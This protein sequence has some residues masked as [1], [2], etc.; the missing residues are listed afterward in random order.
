M[1]FANREDLLSI[2]QMISLGFKMSPYKSLQLTLDKVDLVFEAYE[3]DPTKVTFIVN[4]KPLG[5]IIGVIEEPVFSYD[6]LALELCL[7]GETPR[8]V[9]S[10]LKAYQ[11]WAKR[12]GAKLITFGIH[13]QDSVRT[14]FGG[15][16]GEEAYFME[17]R[18]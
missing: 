16:L 15:L 11:K 9:A 12:M 7:W 8:T 13:K 17:S 4:D 14:R 1:R 2:K 5:L 3:K 10:L 6:K 18:S